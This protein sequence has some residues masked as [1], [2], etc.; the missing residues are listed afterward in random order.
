MV[1]SYLQLICDVND[2]ITWYHWWHHI[3]WSCDW[4]CLWSWVCL[5]CCLICTEYVLEPS[6]TMFICVCLFII[7]F[8]SNWDLTCFHFS[9]VINL[10]LH[11][12]VHVWHGL[13]GQKHTFKGF[14][15]LD[16]LKSIL[17][18]DLGGRKSPKFLQKQGKMPIFWSYVMITI[19]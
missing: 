6:I 14:I 12:M 3:N 9:I 16:I 18:L 13:I 5:H 1:L 7:C 11:I 10:K 19:L 15:P 4:S 8:M 2:D 17:E